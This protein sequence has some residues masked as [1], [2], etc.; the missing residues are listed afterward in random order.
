MLENIKNIGVSNWIGLVSIV[1][2][3]FIGAKSI[4]FAKGAL[5]HSQRSLVINESYKTIYT[6]SNSNV[7]F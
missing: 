4:K 1:V 2:A 3:I 5:E 7:I 6:C